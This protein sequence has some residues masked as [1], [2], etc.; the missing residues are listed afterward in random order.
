M[1]LLSKETSVRKVYL[2]LKIKSDNIARLPEFNNPVPILL[3]QDLVPTL[4]SRLAYYCGWASNIG[5]DWDCCLDKISLHLL[6]LVQ[7]TINRITGWEFPFQP[8]LANRV[9]E[10]VLCNTVNTAMPLVLW[11]SG[12]SKLTVLMEVYFTHS[13]DSSYK[14]FNYE[15]TTDG[16]TAHL[17]RT[18]VESSSMSIKFACSDSFNYLRCYHAITFLNEIKIVADPTFNS[19]I[20]GELL[21][22]DFL[23][24]FDE[25]QKTY[26]PNIELRR[27][28]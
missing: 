12:D 15:I 11:E 10:S 13:T 2:N 26:V 16:T 6:R 3:N 9:F 1:I 19:T 18:G 17:L 4:K 25:N 5:V 27:I 28:N 20:T 8:S 7:N 14:H 22:R 23:F 24:N 21:M